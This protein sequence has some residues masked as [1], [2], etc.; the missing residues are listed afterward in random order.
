MPVADSFDAMTARFLKQ[1]VDRR[2]AVLRGHSQSINERL[3][4]DLAAFMPL[5]AMAQNFVLGPG[6]SVPPAMLLAN[7]LNAL[8]V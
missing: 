5:P 7:H 1:C 2:Q 4:T 6:T 8:S 3:T